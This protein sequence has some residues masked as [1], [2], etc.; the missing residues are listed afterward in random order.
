M[1]KKAF[2][3]IFF[4]IGLL[5]VSPFVILTLLGRLFLDKD[6]VGRIFCGCAEILSIIPTIIGIYSRKAYY[7]AACRGVSSNTHFLF[8]SMLTHPEISI[9]DGVVIGQYALIGYADI[10]EHVQLGARVSIISG[11]YQHG[12]PGD[13]TL[14]AKIISEHSEIRIGRNA[15]IGQDAVILADVGE[16]CTIGAGSVVLKEIPNNTTVLGNP[17][18]KVNLD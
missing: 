11:K 5:L 3:N 4:L 1:L 9:A 10:G 7:W 18:R 16:N 12:R 17:A 6:G 13:R 2:K 15:W 14:D 8:G